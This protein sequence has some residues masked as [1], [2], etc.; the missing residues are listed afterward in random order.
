MARAELA[1][2][3][4]WSGE[5]AAGRLDVISNC[6]AEVHGAALLAA[7]RGAQGPLGDLSSRFS[8][9]DVL[10]RWVPSHRPGP[11]P[12]VGLSPLD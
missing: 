6:L 5:A 11:A 1:A 10:L 2:A 3:A 8:R 9:C 7:G 12:A 4:V